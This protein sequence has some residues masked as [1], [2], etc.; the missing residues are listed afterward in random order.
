MECNVCHRRTTSSLQVS[1]RDYSGSVYHPVNGCLGKWKTVTLGY[2]NR[3][4]TQVRN[5][6]QTMGWPR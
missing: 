6:A 4:E 2:C 3:H 5:K 1:V